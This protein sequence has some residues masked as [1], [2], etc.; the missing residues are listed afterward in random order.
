MQPELRQQGD[1]ARAR[2]EFGF[3]IH[4]PSLNTILWFG[5]DLNISINEETSQPEKR[6][7]NSICLGSDNELLTSDLI[8]YGWLFQ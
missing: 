2:A 6:S 4:I 8:I 5:V 7:K 1:D 3:M